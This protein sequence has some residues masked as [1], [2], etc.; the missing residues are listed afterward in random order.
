MI[1]I[2]CH[3]LP[4]IDDGAR[5]MAASLEM[6]RI[7][8]SEGIS[9]MVL[10]PHIQFGRFDNTL[11]DIQARLT[12]LQ[13]EAA[14]AGIGIE[15]RA[16]AEVHLDADILPLIEQDLLPL[17][18]Q[19]EG[20]RYLLLEL[21]HHAVPAGTDMLVKF[22][23]SQNITPVIAHPERNREL[24]QNPVMLK[25]LVR[26]GC[27]FQITA[28][29]ITGQFGRDAKDLAEHCLAEGYCH[30][31]ATDAHNVQYRPPVLKAARERV[32]ELLG[33]DQ[34]QTL[35]YTNPFN[36]TASLFS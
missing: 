20:Q 5:D 1:D 11:D 19:F 10:T 26:L 27:W 18:G 31:V 32:V 33:E 9:R 16:A 28:G 2:H 3:I 21:P 13:Q 35:F 17:Y 6:L 29:S 12:V 30:V 34:A 4:G 22:L 8:E 23:R 15:L 24:Q 7:A 14:N 25:T 36:I